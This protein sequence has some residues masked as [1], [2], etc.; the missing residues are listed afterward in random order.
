MSSSHLI[1]SDYEDIKRMVGMHQAV[2]FYGYPADRQ[3]RCLCPFHKDRHP[4]MKIYPHDKG[5][6]CFSC[7]NGGD[8]IK[9]VGRLY[10]LDNEGA[11]RKLIEDFALPIQTECL[12]Y[13]EKREREKKIRQRREMDVFVRKSEKILEQYRIFL[14]EAIR[15]PW[16]PYFEEA[17]QWLTTVEYWLSCLNECPEQMRADEG[18]VRRLGAI[19]RK[20]AG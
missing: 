17:L 11:A 5:Y 20:I 12:S 18:M 3:G 16:S 15:R 1:K 19:E 13:R 10:G 14:C 2:E 8:V 9:F 7:G 4:S 6:Y